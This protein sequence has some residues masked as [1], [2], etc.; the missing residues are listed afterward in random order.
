[1]IKIVRFHRYHR[2]H[3]NHK[4][5][6]QPPAKIELGTSKKILPVPAASPQPLV[7]SFVVNSSA[8][9]CFEE[10]LSKTSITIDWV[11]L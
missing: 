7:I 1:M 11:K 9:L 5:Q 2:N 8:T 6:R 10:H 4:Q 3:R